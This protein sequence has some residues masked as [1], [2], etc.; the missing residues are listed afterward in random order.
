[1]SNASDI[2]VENLSLES[3]FE[4]LD[5]PRDYF[6]PSDVFHNFTSVTSSNTLHKLYDLHPDDP[7]VKAI[8]PKVHLQLLPEIDQDL[9]LLPVRS[10]SS[11]SQICC[12]K[13]FKIS[14][15]CPKSSSSPANARNRSSLSFCQ[16]FSKACCQERKVC[17]SSKAYWQ[18]R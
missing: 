2:D 11:A 5:V 10:S 4:N 1:M 16:T 6:P 12:P 9:Q 17:K 8:V 18:K 14:S 3:Y 13:S 15:C 7:L